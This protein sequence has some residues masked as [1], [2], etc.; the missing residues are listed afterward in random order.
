MDI[1]DFCG[2]NT[3]F[4]F[5]K[6]T[7]TKTIIFKIDHEGILNWIVEIIYPFQATFLLQSYIE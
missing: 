4:D 7:T 1:K 3:A 6:A 5:D 2:V